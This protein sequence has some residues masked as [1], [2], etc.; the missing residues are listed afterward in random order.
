M[1]GP[2]GA[3][4]PGTART[5]IRQVG[6]RR[7]GFFGVLA[8][9]SA[10]LS[11]AG[12]GI[13]FTPVLAAARAAVDLL[14]REGAE[15]IVAVTHLS[16]DDDRALARQV[17]GIAAILG[18]H[19]HEPVALVEGDTLIVKSGA[20]AHF[21]AVVELAAR[22]TAKGVEV[23][24]SSWRYE[25]TRGVPPHPRLEPIVRRYRAQLAT[26]LVEPIGHTTV[27][28]DTRADAVRLRET[29]FGNLV[30]DAMRAST[31]TDVALISGGSLRGNRTYAEGTALTRGD[32]LRE[33]PFGN[34]VVVVELTG[35]EL[36]RVLEHGVSR[37]DQR[38][39]RFLQ[40]SGVRFELWRG[41]PLGRRVREVLVGGSPL[42]PDR[43]YRVATTE[44]MAAGGDGFAMLGRSKVILGPKRADLL[45]KAV[46]SYIRAAG[47]AG[48]SPR[49][50]GRIAEGV[51]T[52]SR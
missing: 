23:W 24:P 17:P 35:R 3:L 46:E 25:S 5:A 43:R 7:V 30:A 39:G 44:F 1:V 14:R 13:R 47:P 32:L 21:L 28:L 16:L 33:M 48:V 8:T 20:D 29:A 22:R 40:V 27:A 42:E 4:F 41:E 34:V 2:D 45:V 9:D 36:H 19:D 38:A 52:R 51:T 50:E 15:V 11:A 26:A 49:V 37:A 10:T 12:A 31:R 18:G 6:E